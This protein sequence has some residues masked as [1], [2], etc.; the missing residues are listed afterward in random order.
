MEGAPHFGNR[1]GTLVS[2]ADV[3]KT[4][5]PSPSEKCN[6]SASRCRTA[7]HRASHDRGVGRRS[8]S[9]GTL[10]GAAS[11]GRPCVGGDRHLACRCGAFVLHHA[12]KCRHRLYAHGKN[13]P[14]KKKK[15]PSSHHR[16]YGLCQNERPRHPNRGGSFLY[17]QCRCLRDIVLTQKHRKTCY[18]GT[19]RIH[20]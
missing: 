19:R 4:K 12:G 1:T 18:N 16:R 8:R 6:Q 20:P 2:D 14:G 13:P 17:A 3:P 11:S 5:S 7:W 10:F 9:C 15:H